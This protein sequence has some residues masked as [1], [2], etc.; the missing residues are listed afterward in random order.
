MSNDGQTQACASCITGT[1]RI[2]AVESLENSRK[3]VN[4]NA[5][6][7]VNDLHR[8]KVVIVSNPDPD[9][10]SSLQMTYGV[11]EEISE[12]LVERMGIYPCD[13]ITVD[14]QIRFQPDIRLV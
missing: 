14:L 10:R 7:I 6:S 13:S 4:S 2:N 11:A 12:N 5:T 9:K 8:H 3:V 1:D